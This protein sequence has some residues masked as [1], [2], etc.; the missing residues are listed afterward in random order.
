MVKGKFA[1][2]IRSSFSCWNSG[3]E[4]EVKEKWKKASIV[5]PVPVWA[6]QADQDLPQQGARA[7]AGRRRLGRRQGRSAQKSSQQTSPCWPGL[8]FLLNIQIFFSYIDTS[9]RHGTEGI[10]FQKVFN[11][12]R[13]RYQQLNAVWQRQDSKLDQVHLACRTQFGD[14]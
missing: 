4:G 8:L 12:P 11:K 9:F 1:A 13:R 14:L 2:A 5:I 6:G 7:A 3:H 10:Y